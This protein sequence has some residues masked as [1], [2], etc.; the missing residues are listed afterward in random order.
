M[1]DEN[2][3]EAGEDEQ[4]EPTRGRAHLLPEEVEAGSA[5]PEKQA[6]TILEESA[7]RQAGRPDTGAEHRRSDEVVDPPE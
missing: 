1:R 3:P 5:D 6:E 7:Q 4:G 2:T